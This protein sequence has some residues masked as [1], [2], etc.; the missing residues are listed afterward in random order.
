MA[1]SMIDTV[2]AAGAT[3]YAACNND[4]TERSMKMP[5]LK[6]ILIGFAL[7]VAAAGTAPVVLAHS[8]AKGV[9][10]ERMDLMKDLPMP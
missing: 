2:N 10:K 8:G 7:A 6:T 1:C 9:T 5:V 4:D 3:C